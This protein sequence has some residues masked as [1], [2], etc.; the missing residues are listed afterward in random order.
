MSHEIIEHIIKGN[1]EE[2]KS[3][4]FEQ[5]ANNIAKKLAS[6]RRI[7]GTQ[8][9]KEANVM[10]MGRT[11]LIRRRIRQGKVQKN[12]RKSAVKGYTL[13]AGKLRR[14]TAIQRVHMSRTQKRAA[15]KRK[16]HIRTTVRKRARSILRRKTMGIK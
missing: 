7:I 14:I 4:I 12:I 15:R 13:K 3:L 8:F 11:K 2:A 10:K 5:L 6:R 9:F 1:L 16:T